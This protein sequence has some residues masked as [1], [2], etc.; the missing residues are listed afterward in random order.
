MLLKPAPLKKGD[1]IYILSTARKITREE[2]APAV[3][4]F[5]SWGLKVI[6]F[7]KR[8]ICPK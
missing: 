4:H 7:R 3:Q 8:W 2:I 6:I 1:T 5:E